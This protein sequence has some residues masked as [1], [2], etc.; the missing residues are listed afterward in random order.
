MGKGHGRSG[1][2][3]GLGSHFGNSRRGAKECRITDEEGMRR[4]KRTSG[5]VTDHM[6][7]SIRKAHM[8]EREFGELSNPRLSK[9]NYIVPNILSAPNHQI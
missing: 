5:F 7:S 8:Y 1:S 9:K 6:S 3:Q 4:M 2:R